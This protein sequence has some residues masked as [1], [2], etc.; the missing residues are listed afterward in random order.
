MKSNAE[1]F[2]RVIY[3]CE[4]EIIYFEFYKCLRWTIILTENRLTL[5]FFWFNKQNS[6]FDSCYQLDIFCIVCLKIELGNLS[7]IHW[8]NSIVIEPKQMKHLI[9]FSINF[10]D[11]CRPFWV[12]FELAPHY[13][14]NFEINHSHCPFHHWV[15]SWIVLHC[16]LLLLS[17]DIVLSRLIFQPKAGYMDFLRQVN[18]TWSFSSN[19]YKR[20]NWNWKKIQNRL[21]QLSW[22]HA[23]FN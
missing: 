1:S 18:T 2:S 15:L 9:I 6:F 20:F 22:F 10:L 8:W 4:C 13:I 5:F 21:V 11:F 3:A 14:I 16:R 23:T 12:T 7:L 17:L 19:C